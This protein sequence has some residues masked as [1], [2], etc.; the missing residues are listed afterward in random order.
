MRGVEA[1]IYW[2]YLL[3]GTVGAWTVTRHSPADPGTF[4]ATV[5]SI[6]SFRASQHPLEIKVQ[7]LHGTW[8]WPIQTL[9]IDGTTLRATLVPKE[10]P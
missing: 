10:T 8:V 4:V 1:R 7:H 3:V 6:D 9:Q 2:S 5:T